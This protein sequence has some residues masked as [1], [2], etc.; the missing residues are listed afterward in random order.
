M[1]TL[2]ELERSLMD[3]LWDA[4]GEH[5]ATD[6]RDALAGTGREFAVTTVL[7]MLS[8]LEAKGFVS[9]DRQARPHRYWATTTREEQ[10]A[11]MMHEVLG[12][13]PDRDAVL[14]RFIGS[15]RPAEAEALRRLLDGK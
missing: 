15:V 6:L 13:A 10:M 3:V 2:G 7:T 4:P 14:A 5:T 11:G 9:R 12:L 8:R 1:L